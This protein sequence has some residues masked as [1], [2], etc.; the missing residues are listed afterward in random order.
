VIKAI[1]NGFSFS[2]Q[3]IADGPKEIQYRL[4]VVDPSLATIGPASFTWSPS[5]RLEGSG[6]VDRSSRSRVGKAGGF[7]DLPG[8]PGLM[9]GCGAC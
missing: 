8:N 4:S 5:P 7:G 1:N 9:M 2:A 6:I 3:R